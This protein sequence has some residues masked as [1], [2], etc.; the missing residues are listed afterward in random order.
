MAAGFAGG[1]AI[2]MTFVAKAFHEVAPPACTTWSM[3]VWLAEANTSAG[4]PWLIC[5]A[6]ADEAP[7]LGVTVTPGWAPSNCLASVVNDSCSDAA[8]KTVTVPVRPAV[9]PMAA[10]DGP[11]EVGVVEPPHAVSAIAAPTTT[12]AAVTEVR[13]VTTAPGA[14]PRRWWT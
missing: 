11:A 12:R 1:T 10:D 14:R 7:K 2:A 3:V 9:D 13:D 6:S 8:A 4:A 5:W